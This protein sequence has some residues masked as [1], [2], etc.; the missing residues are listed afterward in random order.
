ML[1][2]L[3][4]ELV[5]RFCFGFCDTVL[6]R[7]DAHYEYI[8]KPNQNRFRFRNRIVYNQYSMRSE[9]LDTTTVKVLGFG[10]S[11]INGMAFTDQDSLATTIISDTLSEI[12]GEKVQFLNVS[13]GSWGPNNCF[14][15]LKKH[16]DFGAKTFVLVVSSHDAYDNMTFKKVVDKHESF[17]SKQAKVALVELLARYVVP[18]FRKRFRSTDGAEAALSADK[19]NFNKGFERFVEYCDL[20][21]ISLTIY[22]HANRTE[23]LGGSY[24]AEGMEIVEFAA[25]NG[26]KVVRDLDYGLD[27]SHYRDV[28]HYNS[29][30]QKLMATVILD[31]LLKESERELLQ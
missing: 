31:M 22:L 11:V 21:N 27:A 9:E 20:H 7:E 8:A 6:M 16:G 3:A 29:K 18:E 19:A 23:V 15:Y 28:I 1:V 17:P 30:G 26:V 13:A 25:K 4:A 14:E 10:D 5:L 12:Y 2:L 24:S